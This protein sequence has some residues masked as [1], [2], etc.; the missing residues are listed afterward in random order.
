M[1]NI[2]FKIK[3]IDKRVFYEMA[4]DEMYIGVGNE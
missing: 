4:T 3:L 1:D 2:L